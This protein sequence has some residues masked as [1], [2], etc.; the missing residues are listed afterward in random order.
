MPKVLLMGPSKGGKT[1]MRSVMFGNLMPHDVARLLLTQEIERSQVKFLGNLYLNLWDCGGQ[2]DFI[3]KYMQQDVIFSDVAV[4]IYVF[5]LGLLT[6]V[7]VD[8]KDEW[9]KKDAF[10]YFE[11]CITR[12]MS[13]SPNAQVYCFLHKVDLYEPSERQ[14][15]CR[16]AEEGILSYISAERHSAIHFYGTS[17]FEDSLYDAFNMVVK[18]LIPHLDILEANVDDI[19]RSLGCSYAAVIDRGTLLCLCESRSTETGEAPSVNINALGNKLKRMKSVIG[20]PSSSGQPLNWESFELK[21]NRCV[22]VLCGFTP[23][24][25]LIVFRGAQEGCGPA[26]G[27]ESSSLLR[28]SVE[29]AAKRFTNFLVNS[30]EL[31]QTRAI[32]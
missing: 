26:G 10:E 12:L 17:I 15:A 23:N 16:T 8:K 27:Y 18:G 30:K 9:T 21:S 11:K 31:A 13:K 6:K 28:Q 20:K 2:F 4:L 14:Q 5:D 1:S 19:R 25:Y 24:T 22:G 3:E 29:A 7:A 32:L